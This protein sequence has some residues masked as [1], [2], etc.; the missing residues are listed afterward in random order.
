MPEHYWE[1]HKSEWVFNMDGHIVTVQLRG[2]MFYA[3][4]DG[5]MTSPQAW[6]SIPFYEPEDVVNGSTKIWDWYYRLAEGNARFALPIKRADV[7]PLS[8]TLI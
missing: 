1:F 4:L 8:V 2:R 7:E 5:D 3:F 6:G